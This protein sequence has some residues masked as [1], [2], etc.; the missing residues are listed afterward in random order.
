M[1]PYYSHSQPT[2]S[3]FE[4]EVF[5]DIEEGTESEEVKIKKPLLLC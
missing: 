2:N 4:S 5:D 3:F 1:Q